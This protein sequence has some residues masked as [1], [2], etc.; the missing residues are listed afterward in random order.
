MLPAR[1]MTDRF[2]PATL[3]HCSPRPD[4]ADSARITVGSAHTRTSPRRP[5]CSHPAPF[6]TRHMGHGDQSNRLR[7]REDVDQ[8]ASWH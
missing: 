4:C 6:R 2:P 3:C 7:G 5:A 8:A 1:E